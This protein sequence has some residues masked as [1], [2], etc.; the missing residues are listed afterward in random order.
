MHE[1]SI[2]M[3]IVEMVAVEMQKHKGQE[4]ESI[5]LEIGMLSGVEMNAFEFAWPLAVKDTVLQNAEPV[6]HAI[7]GKAKCQDCQFE[8]EK[9]Q[10]F[11]PCPQ[12]HGY[13][14]QIIKGKELRIK[15]LI[16][17]DSAQAPSFR[18]ST[19]SFG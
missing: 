16:I 12:C 11:D 6:I 3:S 9:E 14:T 18:A 10:L 2:A 8:F 1:L 13:F 7:K 4:V 5:E 17:T 19:N 15:S